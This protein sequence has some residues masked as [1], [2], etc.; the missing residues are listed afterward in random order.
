MSTEVLEGLGTW[1]EKVLHVWWRVPLFRTPL[2]LP[3]TPGLTTVGGSRVLTRGYTPSIPVLTRKPRGR[4]RGSRFRGGST[5]RVV[6]IEGLGA[7][8]GSLCVTRLV[9]S[10]PSSTP[11]RLLVETLTLRSQE[12]APGR[13]PGS[14]EGVPRRSP[15]P[16]GWSER[17]GVGPALSR[18][19]GAR[20]TRVGG[21]VSGRV[22]VPTARF[23][24]SRPVVSP[25][26]ELRRRT[27][28]L[29]SRISVET[30]PEMS[31][32]SVTSG[33]ILS[34]TGTSDR[35]VSGPVSGP[36]VPDTRDRPRPS[37]VKVTRGRGL[38]SPSS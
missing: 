12:S 20:T 31:V 15:P 21:T 19:I 25:P 38:K 1:V 17:V 29:S 30:G 7:P 16:E 3:P 28:A 24:V 36:T 23:L 10:P 35:P 22:R 6:T 27:L 18:F 33:R 32:G 14:P 5:S 34:P 11:G 13:C 26:S 9:V 4:T 8:Y 2:R 37:G